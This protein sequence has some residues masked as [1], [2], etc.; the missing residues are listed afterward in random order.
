[1][2]EKELREKARVMTATELL[3]LIYE[4]AERDIEAGNPIEGAH[5]RALKR[6]EKAISE[7]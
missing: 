7:E 4:L 1:M 6:V 5:Y 3:A 2:N